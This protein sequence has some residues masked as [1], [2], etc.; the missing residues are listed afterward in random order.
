M[1]RIH[2][3]FLVDS[4]NG[5]IRHGGRRVHAERLAGKRTFAEELSI[6]QYAIV[7]SLPSWRPR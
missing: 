2:H 3:G 7:A 5:A 4:Q 1:K 6:T